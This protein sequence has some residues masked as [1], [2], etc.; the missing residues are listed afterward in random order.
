MRKTILILL[1]AVV[2]VAGALYAYRGFRRVLKKHDDEKRVGELVASEELILELTPRLKALSKDLMNLRFPGDTNREIF[3][4]E[5]QVRDLTQAVAENAD[6]TDGIEHESWKL[7]TVGEKERDDLNLWQRMISRIDF[8]EHAQLK[9]ERGEFADE[10]RKTFR[11]RVLF[12]G[13]AKTKSGHWQALHGIQKVTWRRTTAEDGWEISVWK[14]EEMHARVCRAR[15]FKDRLDEALPRSQDNHL[16]RKSGHRRAL[17]YYYKTGKTRAP[18]HDFAPISINQKPGVSVVDVDGDGFDDIYL[19]VRIGRNVLLRNQGDGTFVEQAV[20]W[21]LGF[22]GRSTCGIFADFDNDGDPDLMLGR[23]LKRCLYLE[24][25]G[26]WFRKVSQPME[27]PY[28]A[29]SMAAADFNGDG[30]LDLYISTYR[31]GAL[32]NPV[33]GFAPDADV[34]WCDKYL[35]KEE[36]KEFHDRYQASR[37]PRN[38]HRGYLDQVGPPNVLLANKGGGRFE[39]VFAKDALSAW[40]NTLQAIWGDYDRDGDPDLFLAHD[41]APDQLFRNEGGER[42]VEVSKELGIT[43][44]GFGMGASWGDYDG[45]G[46][47]DLYVSNMYSKAGRRIVRSL[48]EMDPAFLES[49]EGNFLHRQLK[50]GR[51]ERVSGLIRPALLVAD[52]G[53]SWG[54][55]FVDFDNDRD[56]DIYALSGYFTPPAEFE[57]DID[58]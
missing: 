10:A 21:D 20:D 38:P 52:A 27:L 49:A 23:S 33:P 51:F 24:N 45:D 48:E 54:G 5:V 15:F 47:D 53:W 56:L 19:M 11:T 6:G 36:A 46:R 9:I 39:R 31:R 14:L 17:G 42:F 57:S 22:D 4:S 41:W 40:K 16:A 7:G 35:N 25:T 28:L 37:M 44:M 58:L 34:T 1:V 2:A 43:T 18:S 30:L 55:Q 32:A 3:G 26:G 50:G 13:L 8:F 29:T 12:S